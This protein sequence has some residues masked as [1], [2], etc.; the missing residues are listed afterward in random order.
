MGATAA[1][2]A[3]MNA[4]IPADVPEWIMLVRTGAWLGHPTGP[5]VI[6]PAHIQ[7]AHDTFQRRGIDLVV[8][9]H[10]QTLLASAGRVPLAPAAGWIKQVE[11]RGGG[12]ELWGHVLPWAAEAR[13][14]IASRAYRYL[15]PV[16]RFDAPDFVTGAPVPMQVHSVALTNTPFMTSL[17]ALNEATATDGGGIPGRETDHSRG[18]AAMNLIETLAQALG[19]QP[20]Q[21]A[22]SLGL[23]KGA[24]DAAVAAG[25]VAHATRV[26][27]LEARLADLPVVN[28]SVAALLGIDP[29]SN[30]T[31]VKAA[32]ARLQFNA[33]GAAVRTKLGLKPD[34]GL[35]ALIAA[36][37]GLE[38]KRNDADAETLVANAIEAGKVPPAQREQVLIFARGNLEAA[39]EFINSLPVVTA[40]PAHGN[41]PAAQQP[42]LTAEEE[43][44]RQMMGL[45]AE[46]MIA[47]R[48]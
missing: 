1:E 38:A 25:L 48:S 3:V 8:D 26:R 23:D 29:K 36:I 31:S 37:D 5:E 41:K 16:L 14:L 42:V 35:D 39:R 4:E 47:A 7:A 44:V 46:A 24:D 22:T 32:I 15:S 21:V 33:D 19:Q 27:E 20:D 34:V 18:E 30:E 45:T 6:T 10:H 12:T 40:G 2:K 13:A 28:E 11:I 43:T 17:E 9:W